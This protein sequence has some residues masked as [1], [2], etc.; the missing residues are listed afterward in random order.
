M[1]LVRVLRTP[2]A[3][4]VGVLLLPICAGAQ[5]LVNNPGFDMPGSTT[6]VQIVGSGAVA[7][8][9]APFWN[10]YNNTNGTTTAT[11]MT[12]TD[13]LTGGGGNMME[14]V[15]SNNNN[16]LYQSFSTSA[17]PLTV[18]TGAVDVNVLAGSVFVALYNKSSGYVTTITQGTT[19][20][21]VNGGWVTLNLPISG[22][23]SAYQIVLYTNTLGRNQFQADNVRV[24]GP[25]EVPEPGSLAFLVG[26][27]APIGGFLLR[28]RRR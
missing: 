14:I 24:L 11:L 19:N 4:A 17:S 7:A 6:P 20:Q 3:L 22:T 2:A 5:N 10:V 12:S 1:S 25:G 27:L 16:G 8:T 15:S 23:V 26:S 18:A 28:R 13:V 21:D 9:G